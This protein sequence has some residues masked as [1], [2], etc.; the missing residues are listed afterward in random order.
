MRGSVGILDSGNSR[1]WGN[2]ETSKERGGK[3]EDELGCVGASNLNSD[4]VTT[5][6]RNIYTR[7]W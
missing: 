2:M 4:L 1:I 6:T 3:R 5:D 7:V